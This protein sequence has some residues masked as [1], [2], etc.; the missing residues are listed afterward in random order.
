LQDP[1]AVHVLT[2]DYCQR[3]KAPGQGYGHVPP[4]EDTARPWEEVAVDCVGPWTITL[5]NGQQ[6]KVHALTIIDVCTTLAECIRIEEKTAQHQAVLFV[7]HWLS[8]YPRPLRVIHDQ[9]TEFVGLDFQSML[10]AHGIQAVPTSV[11]NPQANAVCERL[12]KTAQDL[13]NISLRSPPV[14]AAD[15]IELIDSCLAAAQRSLRTMVHQTLNVSPG[16]LVFGRDMLLPIPVLD[17]YNLIRER[18]QAIID[19]HNRRENLRR[20]F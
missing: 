19:E 8:R 4:R 16:A 14:T 12:H 18:C 7:N 1:V 6:V 15:A 2:C 5:S 10:V 9:G 13:L 3:Y 17:D 20:R 11:R